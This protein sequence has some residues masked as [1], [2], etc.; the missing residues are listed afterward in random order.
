MTTSTRATSTRKSA[1]IG[2]MPNTN[3]TITIRLSQVA[4][5]E[6]S[7]ITPEDQ[8]KLNTLD[9]AVCASQETVE[10]GKSW[11]SA[12]AAEKTRWLSDQSG[13][14]PTMGTARGYTVLANKLSR[15]EASRQEALNAATSANGPAFEGNGQLHDLGNE[16]ERLKAGEWDVKKWG[17]L[18]SASVVELHTNG[19]GADGERSVVNG[20]TLPVN[21][22]A[23]E[24]KEALP[25]VFSRI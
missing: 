8:D 9:A 18:L 11:I 10:A 16:L 17:V 12:L 24:F 7:K 14:Y 20:Q 3:H 21:A 22:A 5:P 13:W 1:H 6:P 25:A 4:P 15:Q 19:A 2:G 23:T